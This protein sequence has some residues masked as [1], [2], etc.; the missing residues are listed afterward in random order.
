[1]DKSFQIRLINTLKSI[2]NQDDVV[3]KDTVFGVRKVFVGRQLAFK[4]V[5][6]TYLE[7]LTAENRI[8]IKQLYVDGDQQIGLDQNLIADLYNATEKKIATQAQNRTTSFLSDIL[9]NA[10]QKTK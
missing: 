6:K 1:M 2:L 7:N 5:K 8:E 9:H 3:V 4:I 10:K